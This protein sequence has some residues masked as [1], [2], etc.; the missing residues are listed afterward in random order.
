M[1]LRQTIS[2]TTL[3]DR[4]LL[5]FL[6]LASFAGIV[7]IKDVL[8]SS[9]GV[10]IEVQGKTTHR[11][12][13]NQ[14]RTVRVESPYGHLT[15]EIRERKVRVINASCQNKLCEHQGWVTRGVIICLPARISVS[16]GGPEKSGDKRIDATTG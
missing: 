11:Y 10:S 4:I 7:F 15:V 6:L 5:V 2:S 13:L 8:P 3:G 12:L 16:V 14:N 9:G 1:S